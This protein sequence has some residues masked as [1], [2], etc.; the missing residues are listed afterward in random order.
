M[1][2]VFLKASAVGVSIESN[3]YI[4]SSNQNGWSPQSYIT[5]AASAITL[6]YSSTEMSGAS[7]PSIVFRCIKTYTKTIDN[8][9]V[10]FSIGS[11]YKKK[12]VFKD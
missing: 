10:S 7:S 11:V 1:Q 5:P 6:T 8:K 3:E 2:L 12:I 4:S 9:V